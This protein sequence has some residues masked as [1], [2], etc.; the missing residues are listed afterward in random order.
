MSAAV[1][2]MSLRAPEE[3]LI[4]LVGT[5]GRACTDELEVAMEVAEMVEARGWV[6]SRVGDERNFGEGGTAEGGR[7]VA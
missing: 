3:P 6:V 2:S 4:E 1:W 7:G 5:W